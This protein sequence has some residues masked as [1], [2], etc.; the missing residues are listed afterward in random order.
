MDRYPEGRDPFVGLGS[1]LQLHEEEQLAHAQRL[2][3][4]SPEL[5]HMSVEDILAVLVARAQE[6]DETVIEEE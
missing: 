1:F 3:D 2:K 5:A 4:R 6:E